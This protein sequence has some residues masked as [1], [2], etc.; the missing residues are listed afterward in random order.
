MRPER[1]PIKE[2][3]VCWEPAYAARM[4]SPVSQVGAHAVDWFLATHSPITCSDGVGAVDERALFGELFATAKHETLVVV[5]GDPGAGKSQLI[6][7][8]KLRFDDAI[9]QGHSSG[10][11]SRHL[12]SV[13]IRRESGSLKDALRQL[14]SQLPGYQ[15]YLEKIQAAIADLS[16]TNANRRLYTEMQNCLFGR[17]DKAP[18]QLTNLDKVFN[19]N[20][21]VDWLCRPGGAIDRNIKR[22]TEQSEASARESLPMFSDED[23]AF[24]ANARLFDVDLQDRLADDEILRSHAANWASEHLRLA[25]AGLTG[26]RG[27]TLNEIFRDIREEMERRGEA[28]ALFVE[29]VSTLSVLDEELVNAMQPLNDP[30]LC[31]LLSV[32]GMTIPAYSRLPDNLKG[33]IDRVLELSGNSSLKLDELSSQATDHFVARY[34][35]G[36]RTGERHVRILADDV[37]GYGD[38]QHSACDECPLRPACFEAFGS[39]Q[40]GKANVGLY[41]LAPGAATRL[42]NGLRSEISLKTPRTLLQYVVVPLLSGMASGFRDGTVNLPVQPRSPHDLSVEQ[43]RMLAGWSPAQKGRISYL[44][45]YWTGYDTLSDGAPRL[46]PMLPWFSHPSFSQQHVARLLAATRAKPVA[47]GDQANTA[48]TPPVKPAVT[49]K[50]IDLIERLDVWHLQQGQL[51]DDSEYRQMLAAMINQSLPLDDVR[52]PSH[53]VRRSA[54]PIGVGNIVIEGMSRKIGAASKARFQFDRSE[55]VYQLL[56]DLVGFYHLGAKSWRFDGG[57]EARRRYGQWLAQ[58]TARLVQDFDWT[59]VDHDSTLRYG[60]RFL[61][62]AYRFALRKDL[63]SD[64]GAAVEAIVSF[65]PTSVFTLDRRA[66]VLADS[67]PQRVQEVRDIILEE[68]AVRQG[69]GGLNYIDPRP[70]IEYLSVGADQLSLGD[71]D[72]P[73]TQADY[74]VISRLA[75]SDWSSL[76]AVLQEEQQALQQQLHQLDPRL[77]HWQLSTE[78]I[79]SALRDYLESARAVV[80]ACEEAGETIGNAP[81]Q[82]QILALAPAAVARW[83]SPIERALEVLD[84]KPAATLALDLKEVAGALNFLAEVDQAMR[85]Q[86]NLL[87]HRLATVVTEDDVQAE[88]EETVA[89]IHALMALGT[90]PQTVGVQE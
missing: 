88:Q 56:K 47:T 37:R 61:R 43:E 78:S 81:L 71:I 41:P 1:Q 5:K 32:L 20:G 8:L 54:Q 46:Q 3:D 79:P 34:L 57:Q 39:V 10:F 58:H 21:A 77:R 49:N 28:L 85:Q 64:T 4:L 55:E 63:P 82:A 18:R 68:L 30:T 22:L 75:A 13:L 90:A 6:N 86:Q 70:L 29:D 72:I 52:T 42:L 23:F 60:I 25:I 65:T 35:N 26:L 2:G 50:Y 33:R 12:H 74:P 14:V 17:R 62:L 73:T 16:D 36:L 59:T 44:L 89:A 19:D 67:L 27:H 84:D 11:G 15:R 76:E 7:W 40:V 83:V 69:S 45:H 24:P 87:G 51:K 80:K 38:Q 9:A 66:K 31:P 48:K 53:R